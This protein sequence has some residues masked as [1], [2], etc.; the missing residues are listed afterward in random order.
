MD[1]DS[2]SPKGGTPYYT[3][4]QNIVNQEQNSSITGWKSFDGT[5]NRYWQVSNLLDNN[6]D[7]VRQV[8]YD[9]HRK[10]LDKMYD[11]PETARTAITSSLNSLAQVNDSYPNA[12]IMQLFFEAKQDELINIFS[13]ASPSEKTAA[14]NLLVK[15]DPTNTSK[16]QVIL[17]NN[18]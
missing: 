7:A 4:A 9:Y 11:D 3:K 8:Y 12:M 2:F 14:Y 15:V 5:V 1:Y 16:Y 18:N 13:Q 10:G 6:Y 17:K